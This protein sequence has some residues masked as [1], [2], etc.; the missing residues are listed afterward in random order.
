MAKRNPFSLFSGVKSLENR[1][2]KYLDALSESTLLFKAGMPLYLEHGAASDIFQDKLKQLI[3]HESTADQLRRDIET[4][5]YIDALIPDSRTDVLQLIEQLD[6]IINMEEFTL[7][8]FNNETPEFPVEYHDNILAL[9]EQVTLSIEACVLAARS[10][11]R[12]VTAVQD[13]I[14]KV[15][16]F[17]KEA[18]II[19][20]KLKKDIFASSLPLERKIHLREF[21]VRLD[22]L[23]N[24]AEDVAD[25]LAIYTIKRAS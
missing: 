21:V 13:H 11:F 16:F 22:N 1:I 25:A 8:A 24:E 23:A 9:T 6:K 17:E 5:L 7:K 19:D 15:M 3:K 10:F 14:H 18:D 2:N 4:E 12:D 20:A